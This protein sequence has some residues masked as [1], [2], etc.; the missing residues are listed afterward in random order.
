MHDD[1]ELVV[2]AAAEKGLARGQGQ[3]M[4]ESMLEEQEK[5]Y[6]VGHLSAYELAG[7]YG[8]LGNKPKALE[9]LQRAYD[10]HEPGLTSLR[11]NV[12][13]DGLREDP[14]FRKL[15]GQVGLLPLP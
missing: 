9:Y 3:G 12:A 13:F 1:N 8:L 10:H 6:A 5:L 4:F 11:N 14:A 7:T 15:E 2:L